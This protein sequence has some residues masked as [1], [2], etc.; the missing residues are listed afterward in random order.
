MMRMSTV[1]QG[2]PTNTL[3]TQSLRSKG[4][5]HTT[6]DAV[7]S[8]RPRE[9]T[10]IYLDMRSDIALMGI[11]MSDSTIKWILVYNI[12]VVVATC[13]SVYYISGW[14]IFMLLAY[15]SIEYKKDKPD[16]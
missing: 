13:F 4:V 5:Q 7:R 1:D 10:Y 6:T 15:I 14:M 9:Q 11:S 8:I 12:L 3:P 2:C 16:A